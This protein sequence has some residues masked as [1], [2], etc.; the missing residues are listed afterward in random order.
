MI[1]WYRQARE[2]IEFHF[3]D[4]ADLFCNLL[5]ATSPRKSIKANWRLARRLY[6]SWKQN[7][8]ICS[9]DLKSCLPAHRL[10]V[11]RTFRNEP[12]HGRKVRA[13]AENLR[14]NMKEVTVDIWMLR[15][16]GFADRPTELAVNTVVRRVKSLAADAGL[17][18]GQMQAV[19]WA[20][21]LRREG[22]KPKSFLCAAMAD[23]QIQL[24]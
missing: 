3:G 17:E 15:Y 9:T 1:N 7:G 22:R 6:T 14:G 24:F 19:L 18:P 4:D 8:W 5:A 13:F 16:F 2:E 11:L 23:R 20:K 10:N 21:S 12:L